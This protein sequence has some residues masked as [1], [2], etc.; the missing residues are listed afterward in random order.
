MES[1]YCQKSWHQDFSS[2]RSAVSATIDRIVQGA[3]KSREIAQQ[4]LC[5]PLRYV[6]SKDLSLLDR[7][8]L[9]ICPEKASSTRYQVKKAYQRAY[10]DL[11]ADE[12]KPYLRY[13]AAIKGIHGLCDEWTSPF[14]YAPLI[15][16]DQIDP[17]ELPGDVRIQD[18]YLI[19][20][21]TGL[22]V[23]LVEKEEEILVV[24]STYLPPWLIENKELQDKQGSIKWKMILQQMVGGCPLVFDQA[25]S[26]VA[27]VQKI[28]EE[29]GK[30]VTAVGECKSGTLAAYASLKEDARAVCFN[31]LGIGPGLQ[32]QIGDEQINKNSSK[33]RNF[34]V[35]DDYV[36]DNLLVKIIDRILSFFHL[37][38]AAVFGNVPVERIPSAY[39]ESMKKTHNFTIGNLLVFLGYDKRACT[40]DHVWDVEY[41]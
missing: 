2:V 34:C 41:L 20:E 29:Q 19:D 23:E 28:A 4:I 7:I 30:E 36:A 11:T 10:R 12:A 21:K 32:R 33:I 1:L 13:A 22:F 25:A 39:Q 38:T 6:G 24:F 37:R 15:I 14:G 16:D 9:W 27:S 8:Y 18:Q 5:F 35:K 26:I 40:W 3:K 17:S 31:S